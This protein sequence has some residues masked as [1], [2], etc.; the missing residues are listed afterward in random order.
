MADLTI[1]PQSG[2][3]NKL[4]IQDQAG[5][6]V[7]TTA[8]S[9][10]TIANATI[11]TIT[12][13][14]TASGNLTVS[15]DFVPST[16]LSN[17]NMIINGACTVSQR[18]TSETSVNS[19]RYSACDRFKI[20]NNAIHFTVSQAADA[21]AGFRKSLKCDVTTHNASMAAT[22]YV[23]IAYK[24]E[25]QD[26]Q[27]LAKGTSGAKAVTLSF[28]AK[29]HQAGTYQ[30]NLV[31]STNNRMLSAT[32]TCTSATWEKHTVTFA[33]DT[34]GVIGDVNTEGMKLEWWLGGGTNY[35]SGTAPSAWETQATTDKG[36]S[37]TVNVGNSTNNYFQITGVQLELGSNATPFEHR[38]FGDELARC[39]RYYENSYSAGN[40]LTSTASNNAMHVISWGDGNAQGVFY[41]TPK[42]AIPS[43]TL[44]PQGATHTGQVSSH[45]TGRTASATNI[46]TRGFGYIS[47]SSGTA[48]TY[49]KFT[50]EA[51]AEL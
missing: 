36:G 31:D 11:P 24:L 15:G 32:Y 8:D 30:V 29:T 3:G 2:S 43:I 37:A 51:N 28:W 35:T 23:Y 27:H 7:I 12:G 1:K 34:T 41:N 5:G 21:P 48:S 4:I 40:D 18:T 26:V 9:G 10:T 22:D 47:V 46:G 13:N 16:P 39:Q 45:G 38:S 50:Y 25:G 14:V 42:R 49:V 19:N 33:G 44:R 6:A 20:E 17:R